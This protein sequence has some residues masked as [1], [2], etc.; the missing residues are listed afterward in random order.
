M[1]FRH[2]WIDAGGCSTRYVEAGSPDAPALLLLHGTGGH[3]EAFARNLAAHAVHFRTIA[4]DMVGH[5]WSDLGD[6]P[7]EIDDYVDHVVAFM[8]AIGIERAAFSGVSLGGW[9]ACRLAIDHPARVSCLVLN[10]PGG[11]RP[12]HGDGT[13][14]AKTA[15]AAGH[16]WDAVRKR[17][18]FLVADPAV[19]H[20]DLVAVRQRIYAREGMP[21]ALARVLVLQDPEVRARNLLDGD[22]Y[23]RIAAPALVVWTTLDPT[24]PP[25][26]GE[27]I[28]AMI[29]GAEYVLIEGCGH[30]PQFED[31]ERFN[32]LQIAFLRQ[33][34]FPIRELE[35]R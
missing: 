13:I 1:P 10:T 26:E 33:H 11:S 15:A 16:S 27:R 9:V 28:A 32:A 30:W 34:A 14:T 19:I 5:G 24:A 22:D 23:A 25:E 20:D 21:E 18:E 31:P 29:P 3:V 8:D 6:G 4:M 12:T 17:L 35:G 2:A 7:L